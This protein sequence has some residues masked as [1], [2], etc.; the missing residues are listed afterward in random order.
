MS[1]TAVLLL[2]RLLKYSLL[3]DGWMLGRTLAPS[4]SLFLELSHTNITVT[5]VLRKHPLL[6]WKA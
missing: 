6:Q 4:C 2:C 3:S 1:M 5:P